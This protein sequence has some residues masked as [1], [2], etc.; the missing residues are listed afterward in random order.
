MRRRLVLCALTGLATVV[1]LFPGWL[2]LASITPFVQVAAFHP[3]V[4]AAVLVIALLAPVRKPL[5]PAAATVLVIALLAA[6]LI[7]PRTISRENTRPGRP[8]TIMAANVLGGGASPD[9]VV[10]LIRAHQPVLVS[11]PEARTDVRDAIL[12]GLDGYRG[13]TDQPTAAPESA[14]SVL[15]SDRLGAVEVRTGGEDTRLGTVTVTGGRLGSLRFVAYHG[16]P[17]LVRTAGR[18]RDDLEAVARWCADDRPTIVAGDFNA[19][20]DHSAFRAATKGCRN[21]SAYV[22]KG[23]Q[24]TWPSDRPGWLRTQIDHVVVS[25][26]LVPRRF[27][28][29]AVAGSDHRAVV[30]TVDVPEGS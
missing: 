5:R 27:D 26:E 30:A 18:W 10:Q 21:S 4:V 25:D 1:V 9:R 20:P 3:Q 6:G 19:A 24:G 17:P 13:Y 16:Y 12:A 22:G 7:V 8:L 28:S 14:T 15:V 29:Y 2:G 11:L 23:L